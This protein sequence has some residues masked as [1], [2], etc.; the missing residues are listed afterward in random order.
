M[1][2]LKIFVDFSAFYGSRLNS[3]RSSYSVISQN[4]SSAQFHF[5]KDTDFSTIGKTTKTRHFFTAANR[6]EIICPFI[7]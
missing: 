1:T 5:L 2:F 4:G 7:V 3:S 6:A